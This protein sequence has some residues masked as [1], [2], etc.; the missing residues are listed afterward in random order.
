MFVYFKPI[1]SVLC[2]GAIPGCSNDY[3]CDGYTAD[4]VAKVW[5]CKNI[6]G[7]GG[8]HSQ[9]DSILNAFS[10]KPRKELICC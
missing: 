10:C 9:S 1:L 4:L 3:A 2:E 5:L 8:A 7:A 6:R